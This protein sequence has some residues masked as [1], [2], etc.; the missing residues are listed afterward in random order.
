M[1][2]TVFIV[3]SRPTLINSVLD[4][5]PT[6]MLSL[7]HMPQPV[8]QRLD[9]IR[10]KFLWQGNKER[11][12]FHPVKWMNIIRSKKPGGLDI[13]N[14]KNQSKARKV[15]WLWRY[16]QEDQALWREVI[17]SKYEELNKWVTKEVNTPYSVKS[18]E[19]YQSILALP[20]QPINCQG[21]KWEQN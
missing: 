5:L 21:T 2:I 12:G 19:V 9:K 15:K 11:K 4:A 10:T 1:E 7:F 18:L 17:K 16:H 3:G 8:V 6:Y 13:K 20:Q 14:L